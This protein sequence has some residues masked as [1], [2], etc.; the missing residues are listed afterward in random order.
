[1]PS[2]PD[3]WKCQLRCSNGRLLIPYKRLRHSRGLD[4]AY[5]KTFSRHWPDR[6]CSLNLRPLLPGVWQTLG[7]LEPDSLGKR[8]AGPRVLGACVPL[9]RFSPIPIPPIQLF[10][11]PA[12]PQGCTLAL[13][14]Y[15]PKGEK[16]KVIP[17][18]SLVLIPRHKISDYDC[19]SAPLPPPQAPP[20]N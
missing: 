10:P 11:L 7:C 9:Q 2:H 13:S 6:R 8:F 1:M 17:F 3:S 19:T 20:Y 15:L 18:G 14:C 4:S 5:A 12:F 16:G